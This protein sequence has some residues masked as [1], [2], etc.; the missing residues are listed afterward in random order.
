MC[1]FDPV[2][3]RRK[4]ERY[5]R[6]SLGK[7]VRLLGAEQ[8]TEGLRKKPWR[9]HVEVSGQK[10]SFVLLLTQNNVEH[11]FDAL[12]TVE[13]LPLPTPR[14]YGCEPRGESFGTPCFLA[15]FIEGESL[16]PA[17]LRHEAWAETLYI[18]T[19]VT[20]QSITR[21]ELKIGNTLCETNE[22]AIDVLETAFAFLG[23]RDSKLAER[24]YREL[25]VRRPVLPSMLF[26]NGDLYPDNM[27][28]R[29]KKL[30]GV[31]D[32]EMAGFSDP[33]YEFLL[34]FF[35]HPSLRG[36]GTEE[37]YC[38]QMGF[39]PDCLRWYRGLELFD[40]WH[41]AIKKGRP[42]HGRT[43]RSLKEDLIAWLDESATK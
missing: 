36:R 5:L 28:I 7:P 16:L 26:S 14:V 8:L 32:W 1:A 3:H 24:V 11:E 18:D 19:T 37:R 29:E 30:S 10:D 42:I 9:L 23:T 6:H 41:W 27:L 2:K 13:S 38:R 43:E 25:I 39:D 34:T 33:V 31:V 22:S 35:I 21:E 15:D 4:C 20:L 17:L 40:V 12:R